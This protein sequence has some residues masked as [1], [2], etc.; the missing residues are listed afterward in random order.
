MNATVFVDTSAMYAVLS[1]GEIRNHVAGSMWELLLR[2][3]D[4]GLVTHSA[5]VYEC[6]ALV[7][8]RL[9]LP[10]L[11]DLHERLLPLIDVIWVDDRIHQRAVTAL[12][13]AARRDVS[14]VDWTSFEVMRSMAIT[15]AFAFDDDFIDQGFELLDG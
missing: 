4:T 13:A 15:R 8:R 9:G 11:R 7:Q 3:G 14:L 2:R 5:V 1:P 12:L 10:A 6:S